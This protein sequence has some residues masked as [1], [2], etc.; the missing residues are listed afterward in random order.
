MAQIHYACTCNITVM[1]LCDRS[2]KQNAEEMLL[3]PPRDHDRD[4]SQLCI[5]ESDS[6]SDSEMFYA[7]THR[8]WRVRQALLLCQ[9]CA[10]DVLQ[11]LHCFE[12]P[13]ISATD[14]LVIR[15]GVEN[16][17]SLYKSLVYFAPALQ[18]ECENLQSFIT[19]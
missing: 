9:N 18:I 6:E 5:S 1:S 2:E 8:R 19:L 7:Y 16:F 12:K 4:S 15:N 13:S 11:C 3:S 10:S 17:I 14:P